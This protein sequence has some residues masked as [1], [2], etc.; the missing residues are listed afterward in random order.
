MP[1]SALVAAVRQNDLP[2]VL[3]LLSAGADP[4]EMTLVEPVVLR[5]QEAPLYA[6]HALFEAVRQ[7]SAPIVRALLRAP[8]SDPNAP[9]TPLALTALG[10]A[11]ARGDAAMCAILLEDARVDAAVAGG[12][13]AAHAALLAAMAG[14]VPTLAALARG[15]ALPRALEPALARTAAANARADALAFVQRHFAES[16]PWET[17]PALEAAVAVRRA[18]ERTG[19]ADAHGLVDARG[20]DAVLGALALSLS[21]EERAEAFAALNAGGDGRVDVD[22]LSAWLLGDAVWKE[23]LAAAAERG[24]GYG[25]VSLAAP[26]E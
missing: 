16:A 7:R 13:V 10:D 19:A 24:G 20:F 8:G 5:R 14:S 22:A 4:C 25:G 21:A 23:A 12:S 26:E 18:V 9:A 3:T 2:G 6:T 11:A 15:G 17:L 1:V